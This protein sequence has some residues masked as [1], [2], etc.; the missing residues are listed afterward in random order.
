M[1]S[2]VHPHVHRTCA[3]RHSY[4]DRQKRH[5]PPIDVS[6]VV[7]PFSSLDSLLLA[8]RLVWPVIAMSFSTPVSLFL[9]LSAAW[10]SVDGL[11]LPFERRA[12][13][14]GS[15]TSPRSG[16][17]YHFGGSTDK[18]ASPIGNVKNIRVSPH[19]PILYLL[20]HDGCSI[21]R[22]SLSMMLRYT[23]LSTLAAQISGVF[24]V[25]SE[26]MSIHLILSQGFS[27]KR[28]WHGQ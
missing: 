8:S 14:G 25:G 26:S 15:M 19:F 2:G 12:P 23:S 20:A 5:V 7:L 21:H 11:N 18:E 9:I 17:R 4:K 3:G 22:I 13:R 6:L 16:S 1:V 10:T 28:S 27:P 24:H